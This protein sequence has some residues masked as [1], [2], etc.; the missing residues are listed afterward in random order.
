MNKLERAVLEEIKDNIEGMTQEEALYWVQMDAIC[1]S[2]SVSGLIYYTE[3]VK[4]FNDNEEE[5]LSLASEYDFELSP[6]ELGMVGYKNDM[7]WFAFEVLKDQVF[8]DNLDYFDFE[9]SEEEE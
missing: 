8:N 2:G 5:I 3:T 6:V 9:A 4:F 1:S 7:V